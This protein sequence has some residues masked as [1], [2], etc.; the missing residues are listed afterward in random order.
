MADADPGR[1]GEM[2]AR[3]RREIE[4]ARFAGD[5]PALSVGDGDPPALIV[6][7]TLAAER[8]NAPLRVAEAIVPLQEDV[9]AD[10]FYRGL[11]A[12]RYWRFAG[13]Q[14]AF[15][16]AGAKTADAALQQR[17]ALYRAATA[18]VRR[19]VLSDPEQPPRPLPEERAL[20]LVETL[21]ALPAAER[22]H[23]A[24][25]LRRLVALRQ[26]LAGD[27]YLQT[28]HCLLRARLALASGDDAL[29][30]GWL[31]RAAALQEARLAPGRYLAELLERARRRLRRFLGDTAPP[32]HPSN[33]GEAEAAPSGP[34]NTAT[35][36]P[37][38]PGSL[39]ATPPNTGGEPT[40][41]ATGTPGAAAQPGAGL[42]P[43]L[44]GPGGQGEAGEDEGGE[45]SDEVRVG[46]LLEALGNHLDEA[47]GRD[48]LRDAAQFGIAPYHEE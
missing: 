41:G 28:V 35:L 10:L 33:G 45:A 4:Q 5:D 37:P 21:D 18:L 23:Y 31:L 3:L 22:A 39:R 46:A 14:A 25:E 20:A 38:P 34:P 30:L 12:L 48:V 44:G 27:P 16:E 42:P 6:A 40:R 29:G 8:L 26:A 7:K 13:A 17:L 24:A 15:E 47:L 9:A 36:A 11:T 19:I 32:G 43:G 2:V 1:I